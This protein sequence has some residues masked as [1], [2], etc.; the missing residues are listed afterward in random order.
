MRSLEH[1]LV[2]YAIRVFTRDLKTIQLSIHIITDIQPNTTTLPIQSGV[3][4][5]EV[6]KQ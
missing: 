6:F 1:M 5:I 2:T 3:Q 4:L